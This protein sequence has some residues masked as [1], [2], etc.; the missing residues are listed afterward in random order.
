MMRSYA[1]AAVHNKPRSCRGVTAGVLVAAEMQAISYRLCE[2]FQ[3]EFQ[4][5]TRCGA[6]SHRRADPN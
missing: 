1:H 2:L 5:E 3:A 4:A 6:S